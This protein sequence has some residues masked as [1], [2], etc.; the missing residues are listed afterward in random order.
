MNNAE[1][2]LIEKQNA[3]AKALSSNSR[4]GLIIHF[5]NWKIIFQPWLIAGHGGQRLESSKH[6]PLNSLQEIAELL[7]EFGYIKC[8]FKWIKN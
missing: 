5:D 1:L 3:F 6:L 7:Y 2:P 8:P 4:N